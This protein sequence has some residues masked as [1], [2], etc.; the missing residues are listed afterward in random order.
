M[1]DED[2]IKVTIEDEVKTE[3]I[4]QNSA[5]DDLKAQFQAAQ[6]REQEASRRADQERQARLTAE[7]EAQRAQAEARTAKTEAVESYAGNIDTAISAA[8]AEAETAKRE[9]R[10]AAEA[11][12]FE[13]QADAADRLATA[14]AKLIRLDEAKSDI[15]V[16]KTEVKAEPKK[17]PQASADPVDDYLSRCT[18]TTAAWMRA[19]PE[20]ARILATNSDPRRAAK[21]SAAHSDAMAEGHTVDTPQYFEHVEKFLGMKKDETKI[22]PKVETK[23]NGSSNGTV[24]RA[25]APVAPVIATGGGTSGG[26]TEVVLTRGEYAAATD[27]THV[28]NYDDTSSQKRFRK[29]DPIGAEEFARRKV[30][31]QKQGAYDR[32]YTEQ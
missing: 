19:H 14:R 32:S 9:L 23:P 15:E 17:E 5:V 18:P 1:T 13:K 25:S 20:D 6:Q 21:L 2:E 31:L 7:R 26:G 4:E 12:D 30:A 22:E 24:R 8:N 10:A 28:W 3:V 29:G 27:G 16:R 11:G